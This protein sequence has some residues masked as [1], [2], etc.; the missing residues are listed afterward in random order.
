MEGIMTV[1]C[2]IVGVYLKLEVTPLTNDANWV[3]GFPQA[4][5]D[6]GE[7]EEDPRFGTVVIGLEGWIDKE[8]LNLKSVMLN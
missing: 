3:G 4:V 7:L 6:T 1:D 8:L 5:E 2:P